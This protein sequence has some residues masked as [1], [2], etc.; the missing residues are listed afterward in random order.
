ML[1][2]GRVAFGAME[3]VSFGKQAAETL[4]EEAPARRQAGVPD[5]QRYIK[6]STAEIANV[7]RFDANGCQTLHR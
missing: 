3:A 5:A 6:P 1:Q 2:S 7:V 4:A